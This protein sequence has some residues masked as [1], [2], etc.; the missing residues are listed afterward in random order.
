[1]GTLTETDL[2]VLTSK[3]ITSLVNFQP[4]YVTT[5]VKLNS[6]RH[7]VN[8]L[9]RAIRT[10]LIQKSPYIHWASFRKQIYWPYK[11]LTLC[12]LLALA[13]GPRR[14]DPCS[15]VPLVYPK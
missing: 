6:L 1:M 14:Q 10:H 15:G 4:E 13:T 8:C 5:V 11:P 3:A 12:R 7:Q 9:N 2:P